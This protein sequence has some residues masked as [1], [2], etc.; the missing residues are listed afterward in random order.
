MQRLDGPRLARA[1]AAASKRVALLPRS[2]EA[3]LQLGL[4]RYFE[5]RYDDAFLEL[6]ILLE[7]E[8]QEAAAAAAGGTRG[9]EER[10][11]PEVLLDAALLLEKLRLELLVAA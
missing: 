6:G 3:R 8:Q 11:A 7:I 9:D 5:G 1:A 10:L 2:Q 4:A